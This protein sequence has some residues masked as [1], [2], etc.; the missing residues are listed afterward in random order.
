MVRL[1]S[2]TSPYF[3]PRVSDSRFY[4]VN[5][6]PSGEE[7][8]YASLI[9]ISDTKWKRISDKRTKYIVFVYFHLYCAGNGMEKRGKDK[10]NPGNVN[11]QPEAVKRR[12]LNGPT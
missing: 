10:V 4:Y 6:L 5:K 1:R 7:N 9:P 3:T 11:G 2:S 12:I 8:C